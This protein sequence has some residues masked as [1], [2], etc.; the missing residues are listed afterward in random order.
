[1]AIDTGYVQIGN[2]NVIPE[3]IQSRNQV[4][5]LGHEMG[6]YP[7]LTGLENGSFIL[8]LYGQT[9]DHL[10]ESFKKIGLESAKH[11]RV[12]FYSQGMK[13]RL[14]LILASLISPSVLLLDEPHSG[15]DKEG[16]DQLQSLLSRWKEDGITRIIVSHDES[17]LKSNSD[18][19]MHMEAN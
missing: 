4:Y 11:Q 5:Y 10:S 16:R 12:Q 18:R 9:I 14:K 7:G 13:Q 3:N 17:W 8:K 19:Q 2:E 1:M 15:L 6:F